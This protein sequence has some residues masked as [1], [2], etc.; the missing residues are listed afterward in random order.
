MWSQVPAPSTCSRTRSL[1]QVIVS[2]HRDAA[3]STWLMAL[4]PRLRVQGRPWAWGARGQ[5][6][7][8]ASGHRGAFTLDRTAECSLSWRQQGH[9]SI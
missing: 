8:R 2:T 9:L 5:A 3:V 1:G 4:V 7:Y 6:G